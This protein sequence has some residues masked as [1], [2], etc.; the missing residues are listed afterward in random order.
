[1]GTSKRFRMLMPQILWTGVSIAFYSGM[2]VDIMSGSIK[3]QPD[4]T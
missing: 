1:M 3:L 4:E 2:L